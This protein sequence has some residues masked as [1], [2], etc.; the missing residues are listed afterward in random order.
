MATWIVTRTEYLLSTYEVNAESL[1][2]L[3]DVAE[4]ALRLI[5]QQSVS[6]P[7]TTVARGWKCDSTCVVPLGSADEDPYDGDGDSDPDL[8]RELVDGPGPDADDLDEAVE[9]AISRAIEDLQQELQS[10]EEELD[11]LGGDVSSAK[12][13]Y[14]A[15]VKRVGRFREL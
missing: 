6:E 8:A 1:D 14:R 9:A 2:A 4:D 5:T 10:A 3:A 11:A 13:E 12:A 7:T 15:T